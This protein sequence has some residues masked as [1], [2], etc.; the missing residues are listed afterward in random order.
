[1]TWFI[2]DRRDRLV[3]R[4]TEDA[5]EPAEDERDRFVKLWAES[6]KEAGEKAGPMPGMR[7]YS[8]DELRGRTKNTT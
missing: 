1:V 4:V 6:P 3:Q 7:R 2:V 5:D 8:L